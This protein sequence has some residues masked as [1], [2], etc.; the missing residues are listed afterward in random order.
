VELN[1]NTLL[2]QAGTLKAIPRRLSIH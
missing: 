1:I 2:H